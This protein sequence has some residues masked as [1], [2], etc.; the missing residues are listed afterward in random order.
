MILLICYSTV[1]FSNYQCKAMAK[2]TIN[3]CCLEAWHLKDRF[4]SYSFSLFGKWIMIEAGKK[5]QK[6][7]KD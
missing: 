1:T 4:S 3:L 7:H 6:Q 5:S 2:Y